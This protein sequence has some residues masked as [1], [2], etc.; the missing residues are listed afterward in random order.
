MSQ[1]YSDPK[2]A[3]DPY[4]LPDIEVFYVGLSTVA[5][6]FPDD[7][8]DDDDERIGWY[9]W[10]CFPGCLP[11]SEPIGPFRTKGEALAD[12][13]ANDSDDSDDEPEGL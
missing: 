12:A 11:D 8:G 1:A 13:Q 6:Y 9:Y 7:P 5:E 10:F 4:T 3:N 2:R